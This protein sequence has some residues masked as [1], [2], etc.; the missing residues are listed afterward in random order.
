M[1]SRCHRRWDP[2]RPSPPPSS[3]ITSL[4]KEVPAPNRHQPRYPMIDTTP[5]SLPPP[6][7]SPLPPPS[8]SLYPLPPP[9]PSHPPSLLP[10]AP[11]HPSPNPSG[12]GHS[13][14]P[15]CCHR[16]FR[17]R[18]HRHRD[19]GEGRRGGATIALRRGQEKIREE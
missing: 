5:L 14:L 11:A 13:R 9:D 17:G 8:P 19:H 15:T 2:S 4:G 1:P 6:T 3:A 7:S 16:H 12:V 10:G 18:H